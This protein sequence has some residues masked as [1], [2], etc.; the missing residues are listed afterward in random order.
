MATLNYQTRL[1]KLQ[2]RRFDPGLHRVMLSESFNRSDIP[3][4]IKYLVESM[5]PIGKDYNDRTIKAAD[6]V[7]THL[8]N[9][10]NVHF[11]RAY[12][13]QGSVRTGTNIKAHSDIDLL[14]IVD[15]YHY[16]EDH[17]ISPYTASI[18]RDDIQELRKQATAILKAKYDEV[19][20]DGENCVS[21]FN[22]SLYRK[23]D[24]AF[25]FWYNSNEYDRTNDE[26]YRG[27]FLH[28]HPSCERKRDFPFAHLHNVN[29]KG[30]QTVDGFRRG[31]RLLKNLRADSEVELQ[32]LKSFQLTT[33]VHAI[34]NGQLY[35][36]PG[37]EMSIAHAISGELT[38][39]ID[40][41][42]YRQSIKSPNG[43]EQ[44]LGKEG[45]EKDLL[46]L[47]A[48]LDTLIEDAAKD[49]SRSYNLQNIIKAY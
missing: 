4:D 30:D 46:L 23:V 41:P 29:L 44:P 13:T 45:I 27:I 2:N 34:D 1:A 16:P 21:I 42:A 19:N 20:A 9:G 35:Y 40:S 17:P 14:A 6:N 33:I 37:Q 43:M 7:Q 5:R 26:Y 49:I 15:R 31:V 36:R 3:E 25:G 47:K 48:D 8:E 22:K 32:H 39:L 10:F 18:P 28:K 24:V 38:R 11:A 12:R